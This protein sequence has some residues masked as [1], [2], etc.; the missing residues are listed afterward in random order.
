MLRKAVVLTLIVV[1]FLSLVWLPAGPVPAEWSSE[2]A[3]QAALGPGQVMALDWQVETVDDAGD[4]GTYTSLALDAAGLPHISYYDGTNSTLKYASYDGAAWAIETVDSMSAIGGY[5][6]L[7]LD[8]AGRPHIAY[9]GYTGIKYAYHDGS[10]WL[11]EPVDN[12]TEG[13]GCGHVSLALDAAGRP[14][15]SYHSVYDMNLIYAYHNGSTW[16]KE[17]VDDSTTIRHCTSLALDSNGH[18]HIAYYD[19]GHQDLKYA[20]HDGSDWNVETVDSPADMGRYASLALD[21]GDHPHISYYYYFSDYGDAALKYAHYDGSGWSRQ[22]VVTGALGTYSS[23]ALDANGWPHISYYSETGHDLAYAYFDG[24]AWTTQEIVDSTGNVGQY[25]SLALDSSGY[26]HISYYD[27]I[28]I[29]LK[30]AVGSEPP[31]TSTL[32]VNTSDDLD[33]GTCDA[34]H[35]SLREAIEAANGSD[36]DEIQFDIP[37]SDA[38]FDGT[39]WTIQPANPLPAITQALDLWGTT[40]TANQGDTNTFGPEI[41]LDGSLVGVSA[42]GLAFNS[43]GQVDGLVIANWDGAGVYDGGGVNIT[44]CYIGTDHTGQTAAPNQEGVVC[45]GSQARYIGGVGA[46]EGNLISGN[47]NNGILLGSSSNVQVLGN[48][49]GADRSGTASL[50]NGSHGIMV[51]GASTWNRLGYE[52]EAGGNLISGNQGDGIHITDQVV[53][54]NQVWGNRI[55]VNATMTGVLSNGHDGVAIYYSD[56]NAIGDAGAGRGNVIGGNVRHGLYLYSADHTTVTGNTIGT[57]PAGGID[58]GNAL[59]GVFVDSFSHTNTI[60]PDNVIIHNGE[61]GVVVYGTAATLNTITHNSIT[62]NDELGIDLRFGANEGL[63]PPIIAQ[64][65][66]EQMQGTA[67]PSCLVEIFG[68]PDGEGAMWDGVAYADADGNWLWPRTPTW[69]LDW[70]TATATDDDGNT[71]EFGTCHDEYEPNEDLA[72]ALEIELGVDVESFICHAGDED[73]FRFLVAAHSVVSVTLTATSNYSLSL[74][75]SD[76]SL[77][78]EVNVAG[79]TAALHHETW[80]GGEYFVRVSGYNTWHDAGAAYR[81]QA[82]AATQPLHVEMWIDEGWLDETQ[83]YKLIPDADGPAGQTLVE[84]VVDITAEVEDEVNVSLTIPDD[85]FGPPLS[86]GYRYCMGCS[87]APTFWLG[88]GGGR[89]LAEVFVSDHLESPPRGQLVYRFGIPAGTSPGVVYPSAEVRYD[90]GGQPVATAVAPALHLVNYVPAIVITSRHHLYQTGYDRDGAAWFLGAVTSLVQGWSNG[91]ANSTLAAIYYVD[92]YAVEARD[93]DN[94]TFDATNEGTAN[95]AHDA[96]DRLVEDWIEDAGG[97]VDYLLILGDDDVLPFGRRTDR[98]VGSNSEASYGGEGDPALDRVIDNDF[99]F[100]D[101][102]YADTDHTDAAEGELELNVGRIV[103]DTVLDM[104]LLF[105][106]GLLGPDYGSSPRAV[107][108]SWDGNDLHFPAASYASVLEHVWNWGFAASED[109]V[110]NDDWTANELG[111]ALGEPFGLMIY[112][113]HGNAFAIASP[114]ETTITGRMLSNMISPGF[115]AFYGLHSC[116]GGFSLVSGGPIDW[117][118]GENATGFVAA[119]GISW[120]MARGSENWSEEVYNNF[121]RRALNDSG[122][123]R[124]VGEA[125]RSA[126]ADYSPGANWSC[127]DEKGVMQLNLYGLPW[128]VLPATDGTAV[129]RD[130]QAA[131]PAPA[132]SAPQAA[133]DGTYSVTATLAISNYTITQPAP[134]FDL[135]EVDGF[136]QEPLAGGVLLPAHDLSLPLPPGA[137][138]T[139]VSVQ[140]AGETSLGVRNIPT[141]IPGVALYPNGRD[142]EW[143]ETPASAGVLPEQPYTYEVKTVD[144][145][146]MGHVHLMPVV[147]DAASKQATLYRQITLTINYSTPKAVAITDFALDARHHAPGAKVQPRAELINATDTPVVVLA[148]IDLVDVYGD[149]VGGVGGGPYTVPAGANLEISPRGLVAPASE[150]TYKV[151]LTLRQMTGVVVAQVSEVAQVAAAQIVAF[152]GPQSVLPGETATFRVTLANYTASPLSPKWALELATDRG[153]PI[154]TLNADLPTVPARGQATATFHWET[155]DVIPGRYQVTAVV[156]ASKYGTKRLTQ[157]LQVQHAVYLPMVLRNS[158]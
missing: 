116:R 154:A 45:T 77:L 18:P 136:Q 106:N 86:V 30:Y 157:L 1:Q 54:N 32:I 133:T 115:R 150:G 88:Q 50:G 37:S 123:E 108:A 101:N 6:S 61:S 52:L 104:W 95:V 126:K 97:D 120:F 129:S 117:L 121:W 62:A 112:S 48:I 22:F 127:R 146:R 67:C 76:G 69:G 109:L 2:H 141:Y 21:S 105:T 128:M 12:C 10:T 94:L 75:A 142:P 27:E 44:G 91:L 7:A 51:T 41:V 20:H 82:A 103:G 93:W 57:D 151:R 74:Y 158:Q 24:T 5:I 71:S 34:V 153:Q 15:L 156:E 29:N 135:V 47:H 119:S 92:D 137:D 107:L 99:Y 147:Y 113:G 73:F 3:A 49:I 130:A 132:F 43:A 26:P 87:P 72:H 13:Y 134:G 33:D 102:W 143:V 98:C 9:R 79:G 78:G 83:V 23:L 60:G 152:D 124:P 122:T 19:A 68:D 63:Q 70:A 111:T 138:I 14:H 65:T 25:T 53:G 144:S 148:T 81:L 31:V 100:T 38:G 35:C 96:I 17:V 84:V 155:T 139:G 36:A 39:V 114:D 16:V 64:A 131:P 59:A 125:L 118:I 110:D 46:G 56:G 85:A 8:A 58:L 90:L 89:Y 149:V 140:L 28:G 80:E 42:H 66:T 40:Q 11:I 55:G 4:V 145:Y